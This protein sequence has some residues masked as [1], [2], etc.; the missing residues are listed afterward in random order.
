MRAIALA[1]LIGM[2]TAAMGQGS[3]V[4]AR[5]AHVE[6]SFDVMV[7]APYT[8]T[9]ALFGPEGERT[10]AGR[11]WDPQFLYP[12]PGRDEAGAVFTVKHGSLDSVWVIARHDVE[13]RHFQYVY[14]L[15]GLMATTIDVQFTP[16]DTK[17]TRVHVTYARTALSAEGDAH[18]AAMSEGDKKAGAE[19]QKAIDAY[20]SGRK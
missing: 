3:A 15:A 16:V 11:H 9:A 14:F 20:L 10:W 8:E 13:A 6:T 17:L 18:V 2:G 19:W 1:A 5:R 4:P 7:R 12:L